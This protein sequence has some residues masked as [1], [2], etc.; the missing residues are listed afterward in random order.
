MY[1]AH[2]GGG[3]TRGGG[4][5]YAAPVVSGVAALLLAY[6]PSLTAVDVRR[7]LVAS[8]TPY[9]DLMVTLP[10]GGGKQ[11]PFGTLSV[12]GGVVNAY[13][14]VRMAQRETAPHASP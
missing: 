8:A 14:A 3:Y 10:G 13:A 5:S 7:I 6:F 11:V 9:H 2:P 12:A 1:I 4:T